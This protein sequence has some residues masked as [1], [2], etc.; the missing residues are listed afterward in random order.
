MWLIPDNVS[1]KG[2]QEEKGTQ[3]KNESVIYNRGSQSSW[4]IVAVSIVI[5]Q[6]E[7]IQ[8]YPV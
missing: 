1:L 5:L 7:N 2:L 6:K 3:H 8:C 4:T